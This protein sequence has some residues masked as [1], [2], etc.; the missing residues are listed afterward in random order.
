M[1]NTIIEHYEGVGVNGRYVIRRD[2][3]N[4]GYINRYGHTDCAIQSTYYREFLGVYKN[5]A[6][7][8]AA[9]LTLDFPSERAVYDRICK[10]IE[11]SRRAFKEKEMHVETWKALHDLAAGSNTAQ[12][13]LIEIAQEVERFAKDRTVV[14]ENNAWASGEP[15]YPFPPKEKEQAA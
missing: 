4:I 15:Y 8:K 6:Q 11:S 5:V 2:N 7:A 9:A 3:R 13:R 14:R 10:R 12:D 1:S